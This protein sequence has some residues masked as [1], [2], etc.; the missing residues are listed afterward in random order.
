MKHN[1]S[2]LLRRIVIE[3]KTS[4]SLHATKSF[5]TPLKLSRLRTKVLHKAWCFVA[6]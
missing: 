4:F 2:V 3:D 1:E 6:R 5:E